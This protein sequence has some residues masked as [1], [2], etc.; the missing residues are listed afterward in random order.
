MIKIKLILG[1]IIDD[2][3]IANLGFIDGYMK[4][5]NKHPGEVFNAMIALKLDWEIDYEEATDEEYNNWTL[6]DVVCRGVRA[7]EMDKTFLF[8]GEPITHHELQDKIIEFIS[9]QGFAPD[10]ITDNSQSYILGIAE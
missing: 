2:M 5:E 4:T 9:K 8:E 1:F 6:A 3:A 7:K 10:V